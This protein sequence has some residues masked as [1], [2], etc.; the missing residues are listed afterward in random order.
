MR[1]DRQHRNH[2]F[3]R[4]IGE[5]V[6]ERRVS[7]MITQEELA[8]RAQMHRTYVTDI[9]NGLRN[10]AVLTLARIAVALEIPM[11]KIVEFAEEGVPYELD[12]KE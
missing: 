11:W 12:G 5:F 6:R 8:E 3:L 10:P 9:E 7:L 4:R 1:R 2:D